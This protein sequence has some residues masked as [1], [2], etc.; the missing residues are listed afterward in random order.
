M[1]QSPGLHKVPEGG[2]DRIAAPTVKRI[3][4]DVRVA[5]KTLYYAGLGATGAFHRAR[6]DLVGDP[7]SGLSDANGLILQATQERDPLV[8]AVSYRY[9]QLCLARRLTGRWQM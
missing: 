4:A 5:L 1:G 8:R 7:F 6:R 2:V 9:R 3:N